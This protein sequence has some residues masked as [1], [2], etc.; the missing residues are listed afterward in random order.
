[1]RPLLKNWLF[2][3]KNSINYFGNTTLSHLR[4]SCIVLLLVITVFNTSAQNLVPN[5]SFEIYDTCPTLSSQI[6]YAIPWIGTNNSTDYLNACSPS[7]YLSVPC[8]SSVS[9]QYAKTGNAFAGLWGMDGGYGANYREYLQVKLT[10]SLLSGNCYEV[11]FFINLNNATGWGINNMA[12]HFSNA[13]FTTS[14][15]PALLTPHIYKFGNPPITDTLNWTE[16][17]GIYTATGGEKYISIGNFKTDSQTDTVTVL[18]GGGE[19]YYYIDDVSVVP[20]DSI[21]GG[22][23]ANA[24][25]DTSLVSGDS[26]F[27]GQQITGL[28]C[29]WYNAV[30]TLI[31]SNTSGVYVHPTNTTHY[32]VEQNLCGTIT[33]D[34]VNVNVTYLGI[35]ENNNSFSFEVYPNPATTSLTISK[36]EGT[37]TIIITDVFGKEIKQNQTENKTTDIDISNLQNGIYFITVT[38]KKSLGRSVKKFV[39]LR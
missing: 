2:K 9:W 14:G 36:E 21:T 34:T 5:Y 37:A 24:G 25:H 17:K 31:A 16:I 39:V 35:K 18:I 23:P 29:N 28:N 8:Q 7:C 30:G 10:D 3:N 1:M 13:G 19:S 32:V 26:V 22:M 4:K 12:L 6:N 33:Y 15:S 20:I 38:D 11:S 27:I